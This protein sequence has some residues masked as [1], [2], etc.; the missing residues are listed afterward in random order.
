MALAGTDPKKP[1]A[2]PEMLVSYR[3]TT[4]P[5]F[6]LQVEAF[7]KMSLAERDELLFY[8][9]SF[10]AAQYAELLRVL[11]PPMPPMGR[12]N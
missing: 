5:E 4:T 11:R 10:M 7:K 9:C 3:E 2:G 6:K 1:P 12:A 8:M